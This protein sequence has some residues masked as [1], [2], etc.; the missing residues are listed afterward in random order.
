MNRLRK[1]AI[2]AYAILA[3]A[4]T[5]FVL[6]P[7]LLCWE[8]VRDFVPA[9]WWNLRDIARDAWHEVKPDVKALFNLIDIA[10]ESAFK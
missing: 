9:I 10:W 5:L 7:G 1:I 3:I 6:V 8:V 2:A 4:G